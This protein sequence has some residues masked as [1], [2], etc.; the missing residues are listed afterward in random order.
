MRRATV[1]AFLIGGVLGAGAG[2]VGG[3]F[4]FPFLFPPPPGMDT[5]AETERA[6]TVATGTFIHADPSDPVHYGSGS[7]TVTAQ[8]VFLEADFKVG[9][10]PAYHVYLSPRAE[11]RRSADVTAAPFVDLGRLR[12]FE[13]SQRYALP[14]GIDLSRYRSVVIWCA[15]FSV[16]ISP[17]HL[18][19]AR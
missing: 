5:L 16:L 14:P 18:A 9:P 7:V 10:G 17:A 1:L 6:R 12:A 13:G 4:L 11:I 2:F 15:E 8:S 3:L 19:A